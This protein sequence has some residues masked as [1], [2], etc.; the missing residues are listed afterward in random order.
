MVPHEWM[1]KP[2]RQTEWIEGRGLLVWLAEVFATLGTGFYVVSLF[3]GS[4]WGALAGW[5][6][7]VLFKLPFH[8]FYLGKPLRFWRAIPPFTKAWR[9][10]WM[11]RG[12]FFTLTFS[13]FALIQLVTT[14]LLHHDA[15]ATSAVSTVDV[16]DWAMRILAGVFA[17]LTGVYAGFL[18]TY[19]K[20]IPFWNTGLLPI[21]FVVDGI[22]DGLAL[23]MGIGLTG[24]GV[25]LA[26]V[27][28]ATRT[29]V[30]LNAL[31]ITT[32]LVSASY[33]SVTA[34][35]SV[36]ELVAGRIAALFWIGVVLL[37]ITIPLAI[38][39]VSLFT[40][41]LTRPLLVIAVVCHTVGTFSLK[42]S[43]LKVG[44][45]RPLVPKASAH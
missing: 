2:M 12:M 5:L 14:Y 39:I 27:E 32:Y 29:T 24:Q 34:G 8:F 25:D 9:T 17:I 21:I 4:W 30:I 38:S 40:G 35:Q 36:R 28:A 6:L 3:V 20:S 1:V 31:L 18:M 44:F 23:V 26:V 41:E 7:V 43:V 33:Q 22:A 42:Y 13:F 45:Y 37:G 10:S 19:C 16:V 15:V 11:A